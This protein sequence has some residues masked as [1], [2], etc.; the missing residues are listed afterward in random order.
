MALKFTSYMMLH[1]HYK[2]NKSYHETQSDYNF[3]T[4]ISYTSLLV[5]KIAISHL[6]SDILLP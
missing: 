1:Y 6:I 4:L 3:G 2:L 5:L